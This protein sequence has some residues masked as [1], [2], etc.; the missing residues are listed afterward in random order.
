MRLATEIQEEGTSKQNPAR[1][2]HSTPRSHAP[3][4]EMDNQ[5]AESRSS[6]GTEHFAIVARATN[7]AIR[8]WNV[9]S[10]DL[11]W[12]QGLETLL[13]Y[14]DGRQTGSIGFWQKQ[15]HPQ[16]RARIDASIRAALTSDDLHWTG[17]Y[18]FRR[19]DGAYLDVL[20]RALIIRTSAG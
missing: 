19:S 6:E 15:I 12:P 3:K 7:D 17:E 2:N 11:G 10:G 9:S 13:G 20:E 4:P 1:N 14:D 18:R 5:V 16:D 8:D